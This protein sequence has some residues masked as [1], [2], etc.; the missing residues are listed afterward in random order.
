MLE[1]KKKTPEKEA[2]S[3]NGGGVRVWTWPRASNRGCVER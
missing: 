2:H 1:E 3:Y